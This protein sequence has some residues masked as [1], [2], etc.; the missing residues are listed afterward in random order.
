MPEPLEA[1]AT[2]S[3]REGEPRPD[4]PLRGGGGGL[5]QPRL[6]RHA[7]AAPALLRRPA[8]DHAGG[9]GALRAR[10]RALRGRDPRAHAGRT[11]AS[12]STTSTSCSCPRCCGGARPASS[13]GFFLHTPFPSSEVYRL[14]PAREDVLRGLLGADYVSFQVGDYARHFRSS[15]LRILGVDSHPDSIEVDGRRVGIGVDPI[16]IDTAG[17]HDVL[18]EPETARLLAEPGRAVRGP[19]ARARRRAARLHEGHPAEAARVRA[20]ARARPGEG[21]HRR[22]C[23]R[24]SC[25]RGSRA[26]STC[27]SGTRSSSSSRVSTGASGSRASTPV[28]YLHRDISKPGLVALYR[29]ADVMMVTPLRD[30]M[31]LVAQEFVLCQSEPGLPGALARVAAAL[32]ARRL[33]AGASRRDAREPVERRRRRRAARGRARARPARAQA[34]A[35]DD[36]EARGGAR[37]PQVGA[38]GSSR[39]SGATRGATGGASRRPT[40]R[41]R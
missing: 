18:A 26:R 40:S 1:E 15:C 21:A 35:G 7:L 14:L 37:L 5:L 36:G 29:R 2:A 38:T 16:G 19:E 20:D 32:R 9:V 31:N 3:A 25:R 17:F 33:G 34:A 39:G 27:S 12:G 6:Q 13:V 23:S 41:A 4:L 22:R 30:G 11:R 28:E 24:C 10:Q 8:A